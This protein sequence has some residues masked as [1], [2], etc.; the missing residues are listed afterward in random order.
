MA[1]QKTLEFNDATFEQDVLQSQ[2]PVLVDF[3]A[4]WC[5][6]CRMMTPT[7]DAVAVEYDGKFKVGKLNVDFNQQTA[8]KYQ[9]RGIPALLVFKGGKVVDQ[10]VGALG[11]PDLQKLLDAHVAVS[12]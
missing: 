8:A 1:G 11:K 2:V 6:P 7:I 3:W 5:G 9:I 10:R 4:E 12:V